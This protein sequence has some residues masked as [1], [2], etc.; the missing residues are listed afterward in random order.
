[1]PRTKLAA[2]AYANNDLRDLI[3]GR[4][5]YLRLTVSDL[6]S[7]AKITSFQYYKI[8]RDPEKAQ[9]DDLRRL[10]SALR[11]TDDERQTVYRCIFP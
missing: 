8:L 10:N 3:D 1:M 5:R 2:A 7:R 4:R 11:F 9:I 6:L